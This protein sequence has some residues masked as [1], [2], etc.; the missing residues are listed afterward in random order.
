MSTIIYAVPVVIIVL[1]FLIAMPVMKKKA[2]QIGEMMD[3]IKNTKVHLT[4]TAGTIKN[5]NN[6]P[7]A[8][9]KKVGA[10]YGIDFDGKLEIEFTPHF[11][12]SGITYKSNTPMCV[13]FYAEVGKSY[14]MTVTA[15]KPTDT[16]N[17]LDVRQL[18]SN[19]IIFKSTFYV[20]TKDITETQ[21][22]HI[23]R[24]TM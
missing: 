17:V 9:F 8:D 20:I 10:T 15:K 4:M 22:A 5:I 12:H 19:E 6:Q 21:S 23:M 11:V 7:E 24:G 3:T 1:I 18:I 14:E 2:A 16:A 13:Q